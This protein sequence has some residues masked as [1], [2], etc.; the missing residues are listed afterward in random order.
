MK[1]FDCEFKCSLICYCFEIGL[2]DDGGYPKEKQNCL[3]RGNDE[4]S[5]DNTIP[6]NGDTTQ[7]NIGNIFGNN[8]AFEPLMA[9]KVGSEK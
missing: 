4:C 3:Y 8:M 6:D 2:V 5:F 9:M 1:N 7:V